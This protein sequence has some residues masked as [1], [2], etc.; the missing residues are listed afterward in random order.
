[1]GRYSKSQPSLISDKH[2]TFRTSSGWKNIVSDPT[3]VFYQVHLYTRKPSLKCCGILTLYLGIRVYTQ[4]AMSMA[5][6]E[7]ALE[8][9]MCRVLGTYYMYLTTG[10]GYL[11]L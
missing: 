5:G 6:S 9:L 10:E 1:M 3:G 7:T 4:C 2:L 8:E 11:S